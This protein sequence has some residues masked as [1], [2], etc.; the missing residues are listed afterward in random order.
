MMKGM[1]RLMTNSLSILIID[2][3]AVY[4]KELAYYLKGCEGILEAEIANNGA[5]G[6]EMAKI[7]KPDV[8][9]LDAFMP[10][11]DGI[12]FLKRFSTLQISKKPIIIMNSVSQMNILIERAIK[13]GAN[14]FMIKPQPY[15]EVYSTIW[16]LLNYTQPEPL[17]IPQKESTEKIIANHLKQLG[18]PAH[19]IGYKYIKMA[20][21]LAI[22]DINVLNPITKKLYPQIAIAYST[23]KSCVERAIRHAI[24]KSWS[25][26]N[27]SL[28]R[29]I[30]GY[31][32]K[33]SGINRP[34]NS[35]YIAMVADDLN[36]RIKHNKL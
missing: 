33:D 32:A 27:Q 16:D 1:K 2:D 7:M 17:I 22:E 3:D 34:T 23:S 13:Y 12:G 10:V 36:M 15:R 28:I 30:F 26:G 25:Q 29:S 11:L 18:V 21:S 6:I 8:V 19:I 35:E 24:T 31:C 14:Y 5:E 4:A 9:V 20:L